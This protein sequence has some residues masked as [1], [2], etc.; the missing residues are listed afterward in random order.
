MT[1][2]PFYAILF[3][4]MGQNY[5]YETLL[6]ELPT[7]M[8]QV[9]RFTLKEVSRIFAISSRGYIFNEKKNLYEFQNGTLSALPYLA[10]WLFSMFISVIADWMVDMNRFSHTTTRKI[11]N[12]LGTYIRIIH[13]H[14][15][16]IIII[17][18]LCNKLK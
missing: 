10:M 12:S 6:T 2:L 11:I 17:I 1:S 16:I 14:P 5:G 9:L 4:H 7:Y 3:A 15:I 13:S 18:N 8:K